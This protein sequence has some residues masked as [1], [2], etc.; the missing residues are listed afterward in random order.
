[1]DRRL[2]SQAEA[3]QIRAG[4]LDLKAFPVWAEIMFEVQTSHLVEWVREGKIKALLGWGLNTMIWPHTSEYQKAIESLE[5]SMAVDY[6]YRPWTHDYVDIVLPA[7][8]NFE[9]QA[10]FS[11]FGRTLFGRTPV[12]AQGECREDWKIA[13]DIGTRL[14]Y[15]DI[16]YDG[17]VETACNDILRMWD[18]DYE[19]SADQSRPVSPSRRKDPRSSRSTKRA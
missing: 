8:M 18:L 4:R 1:M 7:A 15:G 3:S 19:S 11:L 12:P 14:G 16:F 9:R 10:P 6:F 13:L 2:L 5:F 17:D